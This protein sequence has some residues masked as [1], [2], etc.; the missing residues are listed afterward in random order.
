MSK[1]KILPKIDAL[2]IIDFRLKKEDLVDILV[3]INVNIMKNY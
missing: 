3:M 1:P 2:N